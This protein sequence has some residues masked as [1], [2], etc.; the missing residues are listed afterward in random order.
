MHPIIWLS[1]MSGAMP[2]IVCPPGTVK[3]GSKCI[4]TS[5]VTE[6]PDGTLGECGD[7]GSCVLTEYGTYECVC[8]PGCTAFDFVCYSQDCLTGG[9]PSNICS[10][11][12]FCR[13]GL[14]EC[15]AEYYGT[16]CEHIKP[17]CN[18]G[19]LFAKDG[20]YPES[21]VSNERICSSVD[22]TLGQC[23]RQPVPHC[24]C[25]HAAALLESE[26]C[27]PLT[28]IHGGV[29]CHNGLCTKIVVGEAE[30]YSCVCNRGFQ[31]VGDKCIA[32]ECVTGSGGGLLT[33]CSG[34][35][36]CVHNTNLSAH[37][38]ACHMPYKGIYC[39]VCSD[40]SVYLVASGYCVPKSCISY[41]VNSSVPIECSNYGSCVMVSEDLARPEIYAC[42]CTEDLPL[43]TANMCY[44]TACLSS[45][46]TNEVCGNHGVCVAGSCACYPGW[47]GPLCIESITKNV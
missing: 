3:V 36:V 37:F 25:S 42:L 20:C 2:L 30:T 43:N 19:T 34:N 23:I 18:E 17:A 13:A 44:S 4:P 14:C 38:C 12:G 28:C 24:H 6:Y 5:C 10:G 8:L 45:S 9:D 15:D 46:E 27:Y 40:S 32:S 41:L 11:H 33:E 29:P 22:P 35:G 7:A 47:A 26:L 1:L 16:S 31:L 39:D 21:C